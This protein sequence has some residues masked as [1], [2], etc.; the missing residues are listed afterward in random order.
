MALISL[1]LHVAS[2]YMPHSQHLPPCSYKDPV[3]GVRAHPKFRMI[4]SG[5]ELNNV[6][7]FQIS[8]HSEVAGGDVF[9]APQFNSLQKPRDTQGGWLSVD[10]KW[11]VG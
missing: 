9:W 1:R 2:P 11:E 10:T 6:C 5:D 7:K 3:I 8:P 4:S